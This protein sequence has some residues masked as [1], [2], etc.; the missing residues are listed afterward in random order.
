MSNYIQLWVCH[1][2]GILLFLCALNLSTY[3]NRKKKLQ[4]L[5]DKSFRLLVIQKYIC[6]HKDLK[7]KPSSSTCISPLGVEIKIILGY[8]IIKFQKL[9]FKLTFF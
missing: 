3:L 6:G 9:L 4:E 1:V 2:Y 5:K 7:K 8:Q